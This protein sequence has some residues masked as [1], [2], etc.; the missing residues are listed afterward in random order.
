[1]SLSVFLART[2]GELFVPKDTLY[3][4]AK[5]IMAAADQDGDGVVNLKDEAE[6]KQ[7]GAVLRKG[8]GLADSLGWQNGVVSIR[9]LRSGMARYDTAGGNPSGPNNAI[10]GAEWANILRDVL[11]F[12][13]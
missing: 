6:R 10:E 2:F 3:Y 4:Q 13:G 9:E 7:M 12:P 8:M 11:A 1:M 5:D